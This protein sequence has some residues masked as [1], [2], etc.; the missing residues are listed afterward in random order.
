MGNLLL[1]ENFLIKDIERPCFDLLRGGG[2]PSKMVEEG[3]FIAAGVN[4]RPTVKTGACPPGNIF[5]GTVKTVPY[6]KAGRLPFGKEFLKISLYYY[7]KIF[8]IYIKGW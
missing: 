1:G 6:G 3:F 4:P 8:E 7:K 5:C 2:G